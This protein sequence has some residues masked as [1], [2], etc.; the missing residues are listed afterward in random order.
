MDY[1]INLSNNNTLQLKKYN[2]KY[3]LSNTNRNKIANKYFEYEQQLKQENWQKNYISIYKKYFPF[4]TIVCFA[5]CI[6]FIIKFRFDEFALAFFT[7]AYFTL[8]QTWVWILKS[9]KA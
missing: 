6:G 8:L 2:D 1:L 3:E 4:Y 9:K 7:A 5:F